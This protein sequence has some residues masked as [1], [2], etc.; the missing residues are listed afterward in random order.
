MVWER[1]GFGALFLFSQH[2]KAR[3]RLIEYGLKIR[4]YQN[5]IF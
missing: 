4:K 2:K 5:A 1:P 3:K